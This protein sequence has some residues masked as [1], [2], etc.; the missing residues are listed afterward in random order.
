MSNNTNT[1]RLHRVMPAKERVKVL[2]EFLGQQT[3]VE[4]PALTLVR[5]NGPREQLL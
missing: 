4:V 5:E 2:L 1:V 3:V